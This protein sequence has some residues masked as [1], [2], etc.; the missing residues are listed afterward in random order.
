MN[1]WLYQP[2][3]PVI[4]VHLNKKRN[5]VFQQV[6]IYIFFLFEVIVFHANRV[7]D[8]NI[9]K[10]SYNDV[11]SFEPFTSD[12]LKTLRFNVLED[13]HQTDSLVTSFSFKNRNKKLVVVLKINL[14]LEF[15]QTNKK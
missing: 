11:Y 13:F 4:S 9:E 5:V 3:Y 8:K 10:I 1:T 6:R 15:Q 14:K 7:V 12:V 2:G